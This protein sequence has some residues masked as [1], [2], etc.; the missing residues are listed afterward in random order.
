MRAFPYRGELFEPYSVNVRGSSRNESSQRI[1]PP[2]PLVADLPACCRDAPSIRTMLS[3]ASYIRV[4]V[5]VRSGL[6]FVASMARLKVPVL[7]F[8]GRPLGSPL[9]VAK[10]GESFP[11]LVFPAYRNAR[12]TRETCETCETHMTHVTHATHVTLGVS[13]HKSGNGDVRW[14]KMAV[15]NFYHPT[16]EEKPASVAGNG[17][18]WLIVW[19]PGRRNPSMSRTTVYERGV[20][21][22]EGRRKRRCRRVNDAGSVSSPGCEDNSTPAHRCT[23]VESPQRESNG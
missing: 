6:K 7:T 9:H 2:C 21:G 10:T 22:N 16:R 15:Q 8:A 1:M 12:N 11:A 20:A 14:R 4:V 5:R 18:C 17:M 13:L 19:V 3:H 23:G